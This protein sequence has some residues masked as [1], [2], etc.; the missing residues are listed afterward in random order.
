MHRIDGPTAVAALPAPL[1][2]SGTPGFWTNG[3]PETLTPATVPTQD[4]FNTVQE[5]MVGLVL[6]AGLTPDKADHTQ[7]LA[8]LRV[9]FVSATGGATSGA[10][11]VENG[12]YRTFADG[13]KETWG[14][15]DVPGNSSATYTVPLP[16][17]SWIIPASAHTIHNDDNAQKE[18]CGIVSTSLTEF[19]LY[20]A[21][22][23]T[24]R[25]WITTRGV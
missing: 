11:L 13:L 23:F 25:M 16:H 19:S 8:A 2:V 17:T 4:W 12:G 14:Y 3:D 5:E 9:L 21:E 24:L 6:E 7:L 22:N 15:V 1:A 10:H 20:N 18:N